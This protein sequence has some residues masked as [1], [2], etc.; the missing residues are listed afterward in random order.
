MQTYQNFIGIDVSKDHLDIAILQEGEVVHHKRIENNLKAIQ[1]YLFS[2]QDLYKLEKSLFCMEH[3][4]MYINWLVLALTEFNCTVWVENPI[5]I[6]R[7]MGAK[8]LKND[9]ADSKNIATYAFR[10][11]DKVNLY[12]PPTEELERLKTLQTL[13]KKLVT[14]K[15]ELETYVNEQGQFS[16]API[17]QL[18][19]E[20]SKTTLEHFSLRIEEIEKQMHQIIQDDAELK[21]LYRLTTSVVGVGKVTAIQLL[22]ATDGFTKFD[23]AKQ[24]ASY[25]GVVP[26]ENSSGKFKGTARVSK[27]ANKTLKTALHMCALSAMTAQGEM[28]EYYLRKLAEGKNKMSVINALRNKIIQRIFACVKNKTLYDRNG[29]NF[30]NFSKG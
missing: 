24:L 5:Q 15:Q 27:M 29:I 22:V 30:N 8:K 10:F 19:E 21:E 11:Q 7:S 17:Q 25:C 16:K 20:S 18:L 28:R 4:G 13:R 2:F 12:K 6:K 1:S 23:T 3:T 26:F 14:H 9:K